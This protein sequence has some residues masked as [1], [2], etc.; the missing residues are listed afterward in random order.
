MHIALVVALATGLL[1]AHWDALAAMVGLWSR[2]PMYSYAYSVPFISAYLIWVRRAE[3]GRYALRGS[4]RAAIPVLLLGMS[5]LVAGRLGSIQVLQQL[6]FLVNLTGVLLAVLGTL[7]VRVMWAGLAYLLLMFPIWDGLT[8]LLHARFQ[9]QSAAIGT[10]LL[11][12]VG[13]PA[14][15]EGIVITLPNVAIEVARSCSGVNYLV[16]VVALGLPLAYLSLTGVWRRVVLIVSAVIIAAFSNGLRVA[17]IAILAYLEIGS[18]LHGPMHVLHGLFVAGVG[19]AALFIGL[20]L[21]STAD[22][23]AAPP[24]VTSGRVDPRFAR[25]WV[26]RAASVAVFFWAAGVVP[27]NRTVSAVLLTERLESLPG[28]LGGWTADWLPVVHA[29]DVTWTGTDEQLRRVYASRDGRVV[30]VYVGYFASQGQSKKLASFRAAELHQAASP[31]VVP[32]SGDRSFRANLVR[33]SSDRV[34][35]F[36]YEIH[37][38]V[39]T[40]RIGAQLHTLWNAVISGRSDGAVVML[41]T[42][43]RFGASPAAA[44]VDLCE[45]AA[46]VYDALSPA[47]PGRRSTP[48][49]R[50][51]Q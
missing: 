50:A 34:A 10:T 30:E 35:V 49:L 2:S 21:L 3:F 29:A 24:A 41:S 42:S 31:L 43:A 1:F 46:L 27:F 9:H 15:R 40:S 37:G 44:E 38:A 25:G 39:E 7:Y 18:P 4:W 45:M 32:L 5:M 26:L 8:E 12:A 17:L 33:L 51:A 22:D 28:Q 20:R 6:A 47:L 13:V 16:A 48:I 11:H 23:D 19:Y 14:L 36:W